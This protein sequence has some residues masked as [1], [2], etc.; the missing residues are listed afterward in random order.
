MPV[1]DTI[2]LSLFLER[3]PLSPEHIEVI[4]QICEDHSLELVALL[5]VL[6]TVVL[7][8]VLP[9]QRLPGLGLGLGSKDKLIRGRDRKS[10]QNQKQIG[11]EIPKLRANRYGI[12]LGHT[13]IFSDTFKMPAA[14]PQTVRTVPYSS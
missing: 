5:V 6:F 11:I 8:Q 13:H 12:G 9:I 4:E 2:T 3:L 10:N 7:V 14:S 1:F